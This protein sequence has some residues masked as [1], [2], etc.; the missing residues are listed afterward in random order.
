[1]S[2]I[3]SKLLWRADS[4]PSSSRNF[5]SYILIFTYWSQK[6]K[7]LM[8]IMMMI[9]PIILSA[10]L[11]LGIGPNTYIHSIILTLPPQAF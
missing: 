11:A 1:M 9:T 3:C 4:I 2:L 5:E 10:S 8:V 6:T 7:Q